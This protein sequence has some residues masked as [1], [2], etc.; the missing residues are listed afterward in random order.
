MA[1]HTQWLKFLLVVALRKPGDVIELQLALGATHRT[2][3]VVFFQNLCFFLPREPGP[4]T[5]PF[6]ERL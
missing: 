2:A 1:L 3:E 6:H 5:T 4:L